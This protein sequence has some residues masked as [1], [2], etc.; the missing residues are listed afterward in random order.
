MTSNHPVTDAA[1]LSG[2]ADALSALSNSASDPQI[3]TLGR[4]LL[5]RWREPHRRYHGPVHLVAGL[6]AL[7]Q[8]GAA[9]VEVVAWWFH[10]AVHHN[11]SPWDEQ[12]SAA[13][14]RDQLAGLVSQDQVEEIA[15]LV[16]LTINHDPAASDLPGHRICDA[17][18]VMLAAD[19]RDYQHTVELL[20]QERADLP[21]TVWDSMRINFTGRLLN[22]EWLFHSQLGRTHWE[23]PARQNLGA[24]RQALF[25]PHQPDEDTPS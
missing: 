1:L 18:L 2:W 5:G 19:W 11:D 7:A 14:V 24:E 21:A 4:D 15:R 10:D 13:L 20:R 12:K 9:P 3:Q 25:N 17:D 6:E 16:L 23:Q 22:R 8:L